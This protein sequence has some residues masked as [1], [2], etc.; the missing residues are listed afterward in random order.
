M[1]NDIQEKTKAQIDQDQRDY[2][3]REQ[4]KAIREELGE[5]DENAEFSEYERK[6]LALSLGHDAEEKLLKDLQRLKKQPFGSSEAT[7]LRS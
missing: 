6:F 3:L 5:N 7:V 2:Y 1:E 4:I